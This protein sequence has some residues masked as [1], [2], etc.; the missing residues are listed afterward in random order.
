[1]KRL[2]LACAIMGLSGAALAADK[3]PAAATTAPAAAPA[4][5]APAGLS[6]D[7]AKVSYTVGYLTGKANVQRVPDMDIDSYITGFREAFAGKPPALTEDQM[8]AVLHDFET[9]MAAAEAARLKLEAETNAKKS[10][11]FL[12]ENGKKPGVST[13]ASGLQYKVLTM[14]KGAKPKST[15]KVKVNYEGH[16][17]DGTL[18]DSSIQRG[19]PASF[20][21]DQVIGGW[22]EGLQLM[23][24][25][26]KFEF[27]IPPALG[28]GDQGAGAIPPNSVLVFQVELLEIL[29][30][31][32]ADDGKAAK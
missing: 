7:Q 24:V 18:F 11:T 31:D 3:T 21:L 32:A 22:A 23:P 16:L 15:D 26:S 29:K 28:Y 27:T 4:A 20:E 14:G 12:T 10:T 2:I 25:G 9:R 17:S 19:E 1:M 6:T 13:T 5:P 8:K 30:P